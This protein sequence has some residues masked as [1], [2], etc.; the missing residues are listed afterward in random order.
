MKKIKIILGFLLVF[1]FAVAAKGQ[2]AY[3]VKDIPNVQLSDYRRYVSDPEKQLTL[4]ECNDLD[5]MVQ[6]LRDSTGVEIAIVI[7][8]H[9][10]GTATAKEFAT[11]LFN[12]FHLGNKDKDNGLLILLVTG[13]GQRNISF[14]TGYGLEGTLPDAYCKLI[15]TKTMVPYAKKGQWYNALEYGLIEIEKHLTKEDGKLSNNNNTDGSLGELM[16]I[17]LFIWIA[18]GILS[19]IGIV[20]NNLF[21][22]SKSQDPFAVFIE[23]E[24]SYVPFIFL[25][26]A[27]IAYSIVRKIK[28]KSLSQ[29]P[30]P[31][32]STKGQIIKSKPELIDYDYR[33]RKGTKEVTF[34]CQRCGYT[35]KLRYTFHKNNNNDN[36]QNNPWPFIGGAMMSNFFFGRGG[37][38]FGSG[39]FGG[40]WGGGS[41]GGGGSST[42]F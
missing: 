31:N 1:L 36:D 32:C 28:A 2:D 42:G 14:E 6:E 17:L 13:K 38:G 12:Y 4:Q 9:Y 23:K 10:K 5:R 37:G 30:C 15:Q 8:P 40:G 26:F 39:N 19:A 7:I 11:E 3:G 29:L 20:K 18:L 27:V 21:S 34:Y 35:H 24:K 16:L 41:S 25:P 33:L 22:K